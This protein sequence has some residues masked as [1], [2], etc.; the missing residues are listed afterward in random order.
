MKTFLTAAIP[1]NQDTGNEEVGREVDQLP[2]W[3]LKTLNL[4]SFTT[5]CTVYIACQ[6]PNGQATERE[7]RREKAVLWVSG[8][9]GRAPMNTKP[10]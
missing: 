5:L 4:S 9:V 2:A 8:A 10:S 3:G 7:E 6:S 1:G